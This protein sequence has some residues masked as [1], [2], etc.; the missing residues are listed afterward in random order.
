VF[1]NVHVLPAYQGQGAGTFLAAFAIGEARSA[2]AGQIVLTSTSSRTDAHRFW[3]RMGFA[4]THV[5]MK[6]F[7]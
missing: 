6:L 1:E 7:L 2:G 5:G 4:H 3:S